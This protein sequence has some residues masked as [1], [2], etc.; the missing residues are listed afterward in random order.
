MHRPSSS[1]RR[2]TLNAALGMLL[3]VLA[4]CGSNPVAPIVSRSSQGGSLA[5]VAKVS[6]HNNVNGRGTQHN[7]QSSSGV[8]SG[9]GSGSTTVPGT[10]ETGEP[11]VIE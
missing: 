4:G 7:S 5:V 3:L 6:K 1:I 11:L 9:V 2:R 10:G 8:S